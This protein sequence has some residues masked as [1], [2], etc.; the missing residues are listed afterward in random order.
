M[1]GLGELET[2]DPDVF[3]QPG[4]PGHHAWPQLPQGDGPAEVGLDIRKPSR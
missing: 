1:I 3:V 2:I 4:H